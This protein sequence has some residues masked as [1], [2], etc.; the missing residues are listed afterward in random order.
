MIP[1]SLVTDFGAEL[2]IDS[3]T[4][5]NS[6]NRV[7]TTKTG[8]TYK[9]Q[10]LVFATGARPF[11]PN[12]P[13]VQ[14]KNIMSVRDRTDLEDLRRFAKETKRV[15]IVGGG[16]IGI[17]TAVVFKRMGFEVSLVSKY[18]YV[19]QSSFETEL[20]PDIQSD[21]I[22]HGIEIH[23]EQ[24]ATGFE[25][26]NN[27]ANAVILSN[28]ATIKADFFVLAIGVSPNVEIAKSSG[29]E[30]GPLGI[31]TNNSL[32]TNIPYIYASG[33]CAE[34]KSFLSGKPLKGEFGTNAVFM[35]K[36]LAANLME[37]NKLFPGVINASCATAFDLAFGS[38][39]LSEE[40]AK[41][42][43]FDPICGYSEVLDKYPMMDHAS[44]VK[45]K[46]VFDRASA[47][48]LGGSVVRKGFCV[49][50]N[51]DFLSLAIQKHSTLEDLLDHQ[52]ST[53]PE[54]AAKPSDNLWLFAA[55][56][57]GGKI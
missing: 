40:Q 50:Q 15:A 45:A 47:R 1:N 11:I 28:G 51:V 14:A 36:L 19:M 24:R 48:L 53:H 46:L 13:G 9:F 39:G 22:K 10:Y 54:L 27:Q 16:F 4:E 23:S 49:A 43:G 7:L 32:Q 12:I 8:K 41:K 29:I 5:V 6:E 18:P 17:E 35:S 42:H 3:V 52:Y 38:A 21:L 56:D 57:A 34:K 31:I 55:Q 2:L 33:D 44:T 37:Q 25:T 20:T 26:S 30:V